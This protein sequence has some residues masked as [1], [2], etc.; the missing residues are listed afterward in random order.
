MKVDL[1]IKTYPAD[2]AWLIYCLRS[3]QRFTSGFRNIIVVSSQ[4]HPAPIGSCEV[5]FEVQEH[6]DGYMNQQ[7]VKLH[8]DAY[9]DADFFVYQD[10]D[11]VFTRPIT[12]EDLIANGKPRWLYTPY[13]SIESGDGQTWKEPTSRVM[14]Q[15]V[16]YEFMRRHCFCIPRWALD[17]FRQWMWKV[18]GMSLERY[19][20]NQPLREFSEF[21][22]IG[23]WLW[24]HHH[25]KVEWQNTD[26]NLGQSYVL[27]KFSH[28]G[29]SDSIR[30]ELE[31]ALA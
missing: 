19:I 22:S 31:A 9:S 28:G 1:F 25:D 27:Q 10:S 18:H 17:G 16:E 11:T 7:V 12:P 13:S 30:A 21:N 4:G 2:H 24:F 15:P 6:G 23:A 29:L 5:G 14:V 8:A 3:I 26:E 20:Q